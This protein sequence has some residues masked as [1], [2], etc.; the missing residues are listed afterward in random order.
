MEIVFRAQF[1]RKLSSTKR[2]K[3]SKKKK[4]NFFLSSEMNPNKQAASNGFSM[5]DC[6]KK[7]FV[8]KIRLLD[9]FNWKTSFI[10]RVEP[11]YFFS[12]IHHFSRFFSV[13]VASHLFFRFHFSIVFKV[14]KRCQYVASA[15]FSVLF[16]FEKKTH[17]LWTNNVILNLCKFRLENKIEIVIEIQ[18]LDLFVLFSV[19]GKVFPFTNRNGLL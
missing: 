12:Q 5:D 3:Q 18:A 17:K 4:V 16:S 14:L 19:F 7:I 6:G 8:N 2:K 1:S 10:K 11:I 15:F 9:Y 13:D